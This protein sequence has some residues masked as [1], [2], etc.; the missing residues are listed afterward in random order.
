[1]SLSSTH[2]ARQPGIRSLDAIRRGPP[3]PVDEWTGNL[4]R[5]Y[6]GE[7]PCWWRDCPT[8]SSDLSGAYVFNFAPLWLNSFWTDRTRLSFVEWIV[9]R[10]WIIWH[11][12]CSLTGFYFCG[13]LVFDTHVSSLTQGLLCA[14][15]SGSIHSSDFVARW[16]RVVTRC[17]RTVSYL[18]HPRAVS[19]QPWG[20][21]AFP[22]VCLVCAR[23]D[24]A[25]VFAFGIHSV[26]SVSLSQYTSVL[27]A[28]S[29]RRPPP[30][31]L[32]Q[33]SSRWWCC[34]RVPGSCGYHPPSPVG[35]CPPKGRRLSCRVSF[36]SHPL[37]MLGDRV[38]LSATGLVVSMWSVARPSQL[39]FREFSRF[40]FRS[41]SD[42][43]LTCSFLSV[44]VEH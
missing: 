38:L 43:A 29:F 20:T 21:R 1:M 40:R 42:V 33:D 39:H 31:S 19:S 24:F 18:C 12:L 23:W 17:S 30:E 32:A 10:L 3:I 26:L 11:H 41:P 27:E 35:A 6:G 25:M 13:L 2:P 14:A 37:G 36:R 15:S 44:G 34:G 4:L 5:H 7:R 16:S 28:F 22:A 8:G 9:A